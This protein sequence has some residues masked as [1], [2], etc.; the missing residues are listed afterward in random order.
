MKNMLWEIK[1]ENTPVVAMAIHNGSRVR[2]EV[3]ALMA[4]DEDQRLREEDPFTGI[5]TEIVGNRVAVF[6]SRFEVDLNRTKESAV[7]REPADAWG[8]QV[9]KKALPDEIVIPSLK[10]YDLFYSEVHRI[11]TRLKRLFGHFVVLDLHSYNH[12]RKGPDAP[13]SDPVDN[14]EVNVGTGTMTRRDTWATLIDRFIQD[15]RAFDYLGRNLDVREN[16]KFRGGNLARYIHETFP[17]SGCVLS[18]EF[19]KFFMDEWTGRVDSKQLG[20]IQEALQSTLPGM[21]RELKRIGLKE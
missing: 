17:E 5:L 14:P 2:Q 19:K 9:W 12:R 6:A 4:I 20:T 11:C 3:V 16:V 10:Q 7:Y 13:P 8:L 15:L 21:M 18:I 1:Q